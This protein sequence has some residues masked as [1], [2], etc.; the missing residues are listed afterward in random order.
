MSTA[1]SIAAGA[2]QVAPFLRTDNQK[3]RRGQLIGCL[4][5]LNYPGIADDH[6]TQEI[7]E[8]SITH[9]WAKQVL[10]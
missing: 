2:A 3:A 6:L 1:G 7:P 5:L 4:K 9:R 10:F 8:Q